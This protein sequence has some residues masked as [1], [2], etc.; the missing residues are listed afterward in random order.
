MHCKVYHPRHIFAQTHMLCKQICHFIVQNED[1]IFLNKWNACDIIFFLWWFDSVTFFTSLFFLW[2][3]IHIFICKPS[4]SFF[5]VTFTESHH[6]FLHK[7]NRTLICAFPSLISLFIELNRSLTQTKWHCSLSFKSNVLRNFSTYNGICSK[8][9]GKQWNWNLVI[10]DS[11]G[12]HTAIQE[13]SKSLRKGTAV[14]MR[15]CDKRTSQNLSWPTEK[16]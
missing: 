8:V 5:S 10:Y 12:N 2:D 9:F 16:N 14:G 15:Q 7:S 3:F 1:S 6:W 11:W 13:P 4:V